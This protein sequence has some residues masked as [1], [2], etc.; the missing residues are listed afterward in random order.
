MGMKWVP[1]KFTDLLFYVFHHLPINMTMT[2]AMK[3]LLND[4]EMAIKWLFF[5]GKDER[6]WVLGTAWR[7]PG[8]RANCQSFASQQPLGHEGCKE[9]SPI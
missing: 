7:S 1:S 5:L 9:K 2:F 3:W 6:L 8:H 4:Y